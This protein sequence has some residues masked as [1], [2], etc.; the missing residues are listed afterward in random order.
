[1]MPDSP[2][3]PSLRNVASTGIPIFTV[4]GSTSM[5]WD[6]RRHRSSIS[7]IARTYGFIISYWAGASWTTVYETTVPFPLSFT[8]SILPTLF[9][10][11]RGHTT[12]GG[13]S[14]DPQFPHFDPYRLYR[15]GI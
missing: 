12:R 11:H 6:V 14:R 7:M 5:I 9:R 15:L 3:C 2:S 1:M 8:R 10:P 4:D 13:K